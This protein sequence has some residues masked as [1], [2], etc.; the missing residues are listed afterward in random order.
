M[1]DSTRGL[2]GKFVINRIDGTDSPGEKHDGCDYF[3]LDLVHDRHAKA[4]IL[5]YAKS[6]VA[7]YPLLARD[8]QARTYSM[9]DAHP[10]SVPPAGGERRKGERRV[11]Q[12]SQFAASREF[13]CRGPERR[14]RRKDDRRKEA[15]PHGTASNYGVS[16]FVT[17][18]PI[19][20]RQSSGKPEGGTSNAAPQE[21]GSTPQPSAHVA[22]KVPEGG[23][24]AGAAPRTF[25]EG[26]LAMRER[27]AMKAETLTIPTEWW[28][29]H[30]RAQRVAT[31]TEIAKAIRAL[32]PE[33]E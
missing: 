18:V 31:P 14:G 30:E 13:V 4:A 17:R 15:Y 7:E 10:T 25:E 21:S 6:C 27:A 8:L 24:P 32:L 19:D 20:R 3:V 28:E 2:Y 26:Q 12:A 33:G 22:D 23:N 29:G 1:G 11:F 16:D 5:A 9:P